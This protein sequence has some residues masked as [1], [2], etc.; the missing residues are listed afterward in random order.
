MERYQ[1]GGKEQGNLS[2]LHVY[3]RDMVIRMSEWSTSK[4]LTKAKNH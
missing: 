3:L 2:S 4:L 1:R